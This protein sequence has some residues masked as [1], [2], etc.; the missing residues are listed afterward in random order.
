MLYYSPLGSAART[1]S[2]TTSLHARGIPA[3]PYKA[4]R[5]ETTSSNTTCAGVDSVHHL[6]W[7][8]ARFLT[9]KRFQLKKDIAVAEVPLAKQ[10]DATSQL[11]FLDMDTTHGS[12][13]VE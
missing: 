1:C 7:N 8:T 12:R 13:H 2:C 9:T 5:E 3:T 6:R 11:G 10:P 4:V